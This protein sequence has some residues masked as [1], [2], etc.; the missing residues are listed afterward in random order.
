M[1]STTR[2]ASRASSGPGA[3]SSWAGR[4]RDTHPAGRRRA[5]RAGTARPSRGDSRGC[6]RV[7]AGRIR[8]RGV[9]ARGGW[10]IGARVGRGIGARVGR[11]IAARVGRRCLGA[12][13]RGRA[14]ALVG[15]GL[16]RGRA[17]TRVRW[18]R[19]GQ[20]PA[21]ADAGL[22]AR[23]VHRVTVTALHR[24]I[25]PVSRGSRRQG[26][27]RLRDPK[28]SP[29]PARSTDGERQ[30][31]NATLRVVPPYG[32]WTT[33][34]T[35][36][37]VVKAAAGL[38]GVAIE[39]DT[40]TWSEQRPEEGGRTQLVQRAAT[41]PPS[42]A[43]P[44][45]STPARRRTS[46]AAAPGGAGA[47]PCGSPTGTTSASTARRVAPPPEPVSPE[48][49]TPRGDRWADGELDAS[50]RWLLVVRE[51]H[52]PSGGAKEVSNEIVVLDTTGE[53][54]V[55][56]LV[57]GPD[58]VANPASRPTGGG[59]AG[60]S[61]R[62]RT[63]PGTAP[64]CAWPTCG[65]RPSA[66]RC[67]TWPWWPGA[68]TSDPAVTATA[69]RCASPVGRPTGR[70]GSCRIGPAGGTS[71]ATGARR[72]DRAHGPDRGRDRPPAVGLRPVPVRLPGRRPGGVRLRA[73]R[74]GPPGRPVERR[75]HGRPRR[76]LHVGLLGAGR[77]RPGGVHRRVGHRRARS[78]Q[79][80]PGT[81]R[82]RCGRGAGGR[83]GDP[84]PAPRPGRGPGLVLPARG[85][86]LSDQRGPHRPRARTTRPPTPRRH[87]R[88]ASSHRCWW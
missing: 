87:R 14:P 40:V 39:G 19:R 6:R 26:N 11:G 45:A 12:V 65:T 2:T 62:T 37:L 41:A 51:H 56:S 70:C 54:P 72:R 9:G 36:A 52:P 60:S 79:P 28:R 75:P 47:R 4:R 85:R 13:A 5:A 73:R 71:T 86:G 1:A 77:G 21:A 17:A 32:S 48:P 29:R 49:E 16:C 33:P 66:R 58:F 61:G 27:A 10:G 38:G 78:R 35:S 42:S 34:M 15:R 25:L 59:C 44:R 82:R 88:R 84:A 53:Q 50:G 23:G 20:W 46:T 57:S 64:S 83:A 76:A 74:A 24:K 55:R 7:A 67:R 69:S 31:T 63:C 80:A 8:I 3:S 18:G 30:P 81:R 43:S 22:D 68:R